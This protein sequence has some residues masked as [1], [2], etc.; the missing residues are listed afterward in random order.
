M[1]RL[2]RLELPGMPPHVTQR[3][4]NKGAIFPEAEDRYHFRHLLRRAFRDRGI[5]LPSAWAAKAGPRDGRGFGHVPFIQTTLSGN[6]LR[7]RS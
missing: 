3:G 5:A 4:I 1:P 6:R 2:P 7:A